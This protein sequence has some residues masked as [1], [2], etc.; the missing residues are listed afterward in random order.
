MPEPL[1]SRIF[2]GLMSFMTQTAA[3][4]V[5]MG[6]GGFFIDFTRVMSAG[7]SVS[8]AA[9]A[10]V[11]IRL[12]YKDFSG[13]KRNF[14]NFQGFYCISEEIFEKIKDFFDFWVDYSGF[15]RIFRDFIAFLRSSLRIFVHLWH[16]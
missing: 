2:S 14:Q 4:T 16:F 13:F 6:R 10:A 5:L 11:T 3:M 12:F 9:N 15:F 1:G 8:R 7:F